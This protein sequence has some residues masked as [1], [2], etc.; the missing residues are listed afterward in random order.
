MTP[1]TELSLHAQ[2]EDDGEEAD[3]DGEGEDGPLHEREMTL[4]ERVQY[5][6]PVSDK[7]SHLLPC[8]YRLKQSAP[9]V[10]GS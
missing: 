10:I 5:W 2:L 6:N 9:S 8:W 4:S 7:L 1:A 3:N